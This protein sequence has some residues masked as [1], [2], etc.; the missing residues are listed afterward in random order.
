M[1]KKQPLR[2]FLAVFAVILAYVNFATAQSGDTVLGVTASNQLIT[3]NSNTPGTIEDTIAITGLQA[4]ENILGIDFRPATNLLFGLGST[5]RLYTLNPSTGVAT[6][7]GTGTFGT[8]TGT[9][10]G[11]D[12]NPAADRIRIVS[13]QQQ[14]L[15]L[16][17]DTAVLAGTDALLTYDAADVNAG[18]TPAIVA[19]AYTNSSP[20][21]TATT[22]FG[23]DSTL[24]VL[25]RQGSPNGSPAS[26]NSGVLTTIG[27]LGVDTTADVGFDIGDAKQGLGLISLSI[28]AET[29]SRLYAIELGGGKVASI[30]AIGVNERVRDITIVRSGAFRLDQATYAVNENAGNVVVTVHRLGGGAVPLVSGTPVPVTVKLTTTDGSAK[31]GTDYTNSTTILSFTESDYSKT[32]TIPVQDDQLGEGN[33]VFTVSLS[34]ESAGSVI[35]GSGSATVTILENDFTAT[36]PDTAGPEVLISAGSTAS[37]SRLLGSGGFAFSVSASEACSLKAEIRIDSRVAVRA[38]F[39]NA[40]LTIGE[41]TTSLTKAG[42]VALRVRTDAR[43]KRKL[44][45]LGSF[46]STIVATATD[47][48]NNVGTISRP[49]VVMTN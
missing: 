5:G 48:Q 45:R 37:K 47:S 7:V 41:V 44:N 33:K 17:P 43:Y 3:F 18:Q 40:P 21:V 16:H 34:E 19:A 12:F 24:D 28:A 49:L 11:F 46:N 20:G 32:V 30:G 9:A 1:N 14:N 27:G 6:Q 15:R 29:V 39:A 10:F 2:N 22:I 26:P 35:Q 36:F 38:G 4:A 25:V 31:A 23:I 13:D 8:L 42:K